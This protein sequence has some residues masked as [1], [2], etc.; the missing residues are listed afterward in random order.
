MEQFFFL[1]YQIFYLGFHVVAQYQWQSIDEK[2]ELVELRK[3][4]TRKIHLFI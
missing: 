1:F 3:T 4:K 2:N